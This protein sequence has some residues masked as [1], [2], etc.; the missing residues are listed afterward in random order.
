MRRGET[1]RLHRVLN[2]KIGEALYEWLASRVEAS[3]KD[4]DK[5]A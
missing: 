1:K 2:I 5:T 4:G 3:K